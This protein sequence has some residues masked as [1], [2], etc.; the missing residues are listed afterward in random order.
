MWYT[1]MDSDGK[2]RIGYATSSD[3]INWKKYAGNPVLNLGSTGTWDSD[4]V[5]VNAVIKDGMTYRMWYVGNGHNRIGYATSTDGTHW[6][7]YAGN[8]VLDVGSSPGWDQGLV[9]FAGIIF[10]S[11]VYKMWY[12]GGGATVFDGSVRIGYATSPDGI[13]W[14]RYPGNPVLYVGR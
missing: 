6:T 10:D 14:T 12:S 3:G 8:P 5:R 4:V 13:R 9:S 7:K 1:G 2:F 11:G